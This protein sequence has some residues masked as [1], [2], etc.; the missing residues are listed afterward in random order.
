MMTKLSECHTG[1]CAGGGVLSHTHFLNQHCFDGHPY[2]K[3]Y[4]PYTDLCFVT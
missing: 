4:V 1:F 2:V 3:V